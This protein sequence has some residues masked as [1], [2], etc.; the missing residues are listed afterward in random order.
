MKTT[1]SLRKITSRTVLRSRRPQ[2]SGTHVHGDISHIGPEV[3]VTFQRRGKSHGTLVST[4]VHDRNSR[5]KGLKGPRLLRG[6]LFGGPRLTPT[7]G[8]RN[9]TGRPVTPGGPLPSGVRP[10][11]GMVLTTP[12]VPPSLT[13]PSICLGLPVTETQSCSSEPESRFL[14]RRKV[15]SRVKMIPFQGSGKSGNVHMADVP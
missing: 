12:S 4:V 3:L 11:P 7:V 1:G 5:V 14:S 9:T 15:F 8:C 6:T 13:E 2:S 10:S